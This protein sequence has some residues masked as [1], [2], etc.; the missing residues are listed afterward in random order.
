[1]D[2]LF[3]FFNQGQDPNKISK[4]DFREFV[5][6][7]LKVK[8]IREMDLELF[9]KSSFT[10]QAKDHIDR[11]DFRNLFENAIRDARAR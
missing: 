9:L 3:D 7:N 5:L 6:L 10:L 4:K 2:M 1:M 11:N 8:N